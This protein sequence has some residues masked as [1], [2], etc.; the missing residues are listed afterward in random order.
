MFSTI[1][2]H[3]FNN[4]EK[5]N[6]IKKTIFT[7]HK[8]RQKKT[9]EAQRRQTGRFCTLLSIV[10]P[11]LTANCSRPF[12]AA[13]YHTRCLERS[14]ESP[15][16]SAALLRPEPCAGCVNTHHPGCLQ[17]QRLGA[18]GGAPEGTDPALGVGALWG[19][20]REILSLPHTSSFFHP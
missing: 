15:S 7:R 6:I 19:S 12:R 3:Y 4:P 16:S 2:I 13:K 17:L 11:A 14:D 8:K 20:S 9:P 18:R 10:C 1:S 5:T